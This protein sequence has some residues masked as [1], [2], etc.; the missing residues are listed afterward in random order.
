MNK[1]EI[2]QQIADDVKRTFQE[3]YF[4]QFKY[5][6]DGQQAIKEFAKQYLDSIK[7]RLSANG[8]TIKTVKLPR[9]LKKYYKKTVGILPIEISINYQ[10]DNLE[11]EVET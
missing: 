7:E 4:K 10:L 2:M 11:I 5:R 9:K 6:E 1:D 3:Y 8:Y